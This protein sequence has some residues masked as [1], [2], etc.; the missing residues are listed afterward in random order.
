[1]TKKQ[2][3]LHGLCLK[4]LFLQEHFFGAINILLGGKPFQKAE[5]QKFF[6]TNLNWSYIE[7]KLR[8]NEAKRICGET[9]CLTKWQAKI[10][11]DFFSN[12]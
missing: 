5:V 3:S 11:K 12:R 4:V 7:Q 10:I 6:Y 8:G 1:M 9:K 2:F